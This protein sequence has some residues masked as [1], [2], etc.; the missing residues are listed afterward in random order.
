MG[1]L[2]YLTLSMELVIDYRSK[3]VKLTAP[4]YSL[5]APA[6]STTDRRL[7]SNHWG[8]THMAFEQKTPAS[9][10]LQ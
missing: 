8:W 9:W 7:K 2:S 6:H 1:L 4:T 3:N 5:H 10:L